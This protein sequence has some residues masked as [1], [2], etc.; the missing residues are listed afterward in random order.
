MKKIMKKLGTILLL[1]LLLFCNTLSVYAIEG[2]DY[3]NANVGVEYSNVKDYLDAEG[4]TYGDLI[5]DEYKHIM[6]KGTS[7]SNYIIGVKSNDI[8]S[9]TLT[10]SNNALKI[11][12]SLSDTSNFEFDYYVLAADMYQKSFSY[13]RSPRKYQGIDFNMDFSSNIDLAPFSNNSLLSQ[14][15]TIL[16]SDYDFYAPDDIA[17][18]SPTIALQIAD[19]NNII[20]HSNSASSSLVTNN[21]IADGASAVSGS[22]ETYYVEAPVT[23]SIVCDYTILVPKSL[24]LQGEDVTKFEIKAKGSIDPRVQITVTTAPSFDM[25]NSTGTETQQAQVSLDAT[26]KSEDLSPYTYD[27]REGTITFPITKL[28]T[29]SGTISFEISLKDVTSP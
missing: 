11:N 4:Y 23:S 1:T 13:V 15:D 21:V 9:F 3:I 22:G 28:G 29:Y 7:Y 18:L 12:T 24:D 16:Y 26:F 27:T 8:N 25:V 14:Y 10:S 20:Y 17:T 5:N 19:Y 6:F 2:E